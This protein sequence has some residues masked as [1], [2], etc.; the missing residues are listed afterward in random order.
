MYSVVLQPEHVLCLTGAVIE[1]ASRCQA[2]AYLD[3]LRDFIALVKLLLFTSKRLR[4]GAAGW[5]EE[6]IAEKTPNTQ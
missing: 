1:A 3:L 2:A 6:A 5:L 4:T